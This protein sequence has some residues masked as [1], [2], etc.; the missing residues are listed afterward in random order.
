MN[1]QFSP[2]SAL[3]IILLLFSSTALSGC[4]SSGGGPVDLYIVNFENET[5]NVSVYIYADSEEEQF[6]TTVSVGPRGNS[7]VS[8][9]VP[10]GGYRV[11]ASSQGFQSDFLYEPGGCESGKIAVTIE[12][13][14]PP[15]IEQSYC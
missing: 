4:L 10:P 14:G 2:V 3:I 6:N 8:E 7:S 5:R 1:R 9:V 13:N 11:V 12:P 15:I